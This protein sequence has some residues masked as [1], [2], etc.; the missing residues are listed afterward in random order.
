MPIIAF[1]SLKTERAEKTQNIIEAPSIVK[2]DN[3]LDQ[4]QSFD[5]ANQRF[6]ELAAAQHF[7][8]ILLAA[9]KR[10]S[11]IKISSENTRVSK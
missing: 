2:V 3:Y 5:T 4:K 9:T 7:S 11:K 10:M 8:A 6:S 1:A